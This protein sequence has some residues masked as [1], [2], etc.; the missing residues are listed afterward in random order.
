MNIVIAIDSFKGSLT[1]IEAGN[2]VKEA[3]L[4]I[5]NKNQVFVRPLA[6][7][8]EGTVE[9]LYQGLDGEMVSCLV[10]GP[11][12]DKIIAKYCILSDKTTAVMEMSAAAGITLLKREQL[13]PLYTTTFG[14]GE[15]IRDAVS[16]GCRKFIIGIGGSATN[17]GGVGMLSALGFEFLGKDYKPIP[18]GAIGLQQLCTIKSDNTLKELCKCEF[19]IACDVENAL[20]GENGCSKIFSIQK[21]ATLQMAEEMDKWMENYANICKSVFKDADLD[22]KGSGAAGGLGFAFRTFLNAKLIKGAE[23]IINETGLE[24]YIKNADLV[25]TGEGRLDGQTAMGK[26]PIVVARLAKKHNKKV[27]AF[28]GC[29]GEG[30]KILNS[31][32]IDA[33]F[34][35]LKNI[36]TLDEALNKDNAYKNLSDTAYQVFRII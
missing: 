23:L 2:A 16:K 26:A 13:N 22:F 20:C 27:I 3:A 36:V 1:S 8:G 29:I 12:G 31:E 7:G 35:I 28:S 34:P 4:R 21:G 24:Q 30:A 32:G 33:Y 14:V 17:D 5:D 9:A 6:D 11:L 18:F 10:T 15:M 25:V 19:K